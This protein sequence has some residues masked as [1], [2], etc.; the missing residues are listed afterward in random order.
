M[1]GG[2]AE[3]SLEMAVAAKPWFEEF[4]LS[5]EAQA[6]TGKVN[7]RA[8]AKL[9]Q[10]LRVFKRNDAPRQNKRGHLPAGSRYLPSFTEVFDMVSE[11]ATVGGT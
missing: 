8:T 7:S 11:K 9:T 1:V 2:E 4:D 5:D 6:N 3:G 10:E